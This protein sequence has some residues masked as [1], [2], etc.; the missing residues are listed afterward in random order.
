ME[1]DELEKLTGILLLAVS[2][3]VIMLLVG[4]AYQTLAE[5]SVEL[6]FIFVGAVATYGV[7]FL[8]FPQKSVLEKTLKFNWTDVQLMRSAVS[9]DVP[10]MPDLS[11]LNIH[12]SRRSD[13][14]DNPH[15]P[16]YIVNTKTKKAYWV[17]TELLILNKRSIIHSNTHKNKTDL[18][19]YLE[20][21]D[22]RL[23]PK[24]PSFEELAPKL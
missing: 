16:Y 7:K 8:F 19:K 3:L 12:Y 11:Y 18:E 9:K 23:I 22:I 5:A 24:N 4:L 6:A 13:T 14:A 20:D 17:S 1:R 15:I 21:N 2:I 10:D